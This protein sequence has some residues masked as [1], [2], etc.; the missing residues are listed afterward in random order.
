MQ[1]LKLV[2]IRESSCERQYYYIPKYRILLMIIRKVYSLTLWRLINLVR[3]LLTDWI[4][5]LGWGRIAAG[6]LGWAALGSWVPA[7]CWASP[8][9]GS[10]LIAT[11]AVNQRV[12]QHLIPLVL[13]YNY[14]I[15]YNVKLHFTPVDYRLF[16]LLRDSFRDIFLK[17]LFER[18][19]SLQVIRAEILY[20]CLA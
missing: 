13:S 10:R 6:N 17:I 1:C 11:L 18:L 4:H 8:H 5:L 16:I 15:R 9:R 7:C 14:I 2:Q 3:P 20:Y 19:S 12:L